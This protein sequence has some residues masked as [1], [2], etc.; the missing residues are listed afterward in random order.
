MAI[1]NLNKLSLTELKKVI[2]KAEALIK[3]KQGAE[4][5]AL[6]RQITKL[7]NKSGMTVEEVF[8]MKSTGKTAAKKRTKVAPKYQNPQDPK[9]KWTGRGRQPK[10]VV[11]AI[12][13]GKELDDLAI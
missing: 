2:T 11:E 9:Q 8:G 1:P 12:A 7:A 6:R 3:K 5:K 4:A 13:S 10:W